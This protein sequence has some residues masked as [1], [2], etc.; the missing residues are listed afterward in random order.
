LT[1]P[2]PMG[3]LCYLQ[4]FRRLAMAMNEETI[5]HPP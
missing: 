2:S 4:A 5:P 1:K 3:E